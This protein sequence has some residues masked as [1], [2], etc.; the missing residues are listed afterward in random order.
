MYKLPSLQHFVYFLKHIV[1][2]EK[3]IYLINDNVKMY[4][5]KCWLINCFSNL[6]KNMYFFFFKILK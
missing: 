1:S 3:Q 4:N 6:S 2:M 5:K